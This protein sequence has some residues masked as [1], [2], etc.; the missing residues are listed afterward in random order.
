MYSSRNIRVA[1][2]RLCDII[3]INTC[4][5]DGFLLVTLSNVGF[6][7]QR[8]S[9]FNFVFMF[10]RFHVFTCEFFFITFFFIDCRRWR[11]KLHRFILFIQ[12]A[13]IPVKWKTF[14]TISDVETTPSL[15]SQHSI[16]TK[17]GGKTWDNTLNFKFLNFTTKNQKIKTQ[18]I[19]IN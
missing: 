10:L 3:L 16:T 15:L 18:T 17:M 19:T 7:Y 6:F 4:E 12:R 13:R 14:Y 11:E 8:P 5:V 2:F 1:H 9:F